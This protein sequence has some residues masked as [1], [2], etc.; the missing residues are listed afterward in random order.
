MN[1]GTGTKHRTGVGFRPLEAD[2][3]GNLPATTPPR[4]LD[5]L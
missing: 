3:H 4:G 2:A 5:L 1:V